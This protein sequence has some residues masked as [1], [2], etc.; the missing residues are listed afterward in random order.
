M[1]FHDFPD[2][3]FVARKDSPLII[4]QNEDGCYIASDVPAILDSTRT[5]Y[6]IGNLEMAQLTADS[7]HFYNIDREEIEK[8]PVQIQWDAESAEKGGYAHFMLKEIHE[9]PQAVRDT[10]QSYLNEQGEIDFSAAALDDAFLKQLERI[11]FVACGSAYHV[12]AAAKYIIEAMTDLPVETDLASEFRYRDPKL[13]KNSLVVI[14]SQSGETADSL[15]ALRLAK[16]KGVPVLG[17]VNVVGS[18]IARESGLPPVHLCRTG[19]LGG[20]HQGLQRP[21][22]GGLSALHQ[23]GPGARLHR[24]AALPR[25]SSLSCRPC[26]KRSSGCWRT[27]SASSGSPASTPTPTTS[28]L[29]GAGWTTPSAWKEA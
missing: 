6:Y 28:S 23:I 20:H 25:R 11:Y 15:A 18:S 12:G 19:D 1:M 21:A 27:R 16:D 9:Q 3:L 22:G 13:V 29:S 7:V 8:Q 14:V 17:I 24:R 2:S 10:I 5:V 26:R 4:G